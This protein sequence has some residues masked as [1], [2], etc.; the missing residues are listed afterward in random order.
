M[1]RNYNGPVN[2]SFI[3]ALQELC[4]EYVK[5]RSELFG[6]LAQEGTLNLATNLDF[7]GEVDC[8]SVKHTL[9]T[10]DDVQ[11]F[12]TGLIS[13][14]INALRDYCYNVEK[15]PF[16]E[17]LIKFIINSGGYF[18]AEN[19]LRAMY[20]EAEHIRL[21]ADTETE[22]APL[23]PLQMLMKECLELAE[24][25]MERT[26]AKNPDAITIRT[27]DYDDFMDFEG[28]HV[29]G[30]LYWN[31]WNYR[32]F[33]TE[34]S[35]VFGCG[36]HKRYV[37]LKYEYD[38]EEIPIYLVRYYYREDDEKFGDD[39]EYAVRLLID[40]HKDLSKLASELGFEFISEVDYDA[41]PA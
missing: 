14:K 15:D 40:L 22:S 29:G 19:E 31:R 38:D 21:E 5:P 33:G 25:I 10:E 36:D 35:V 28:D 12:I 37:K 23:T 9:S 3:R 13:K 27:Q 6:K 32:Y 11:A 16:T 24:E 30:T 34:Y 39:D 4:R 7:F 26:R 8:C 18:P 17:L 2:R 41:V 1:I 20:G